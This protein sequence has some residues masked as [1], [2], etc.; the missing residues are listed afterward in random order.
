MY[1][2]C[3]TESQIMT[4]K[5]LKRRNTIIYEYWK[6]C[7]FLYET[8]LRTHM[9]NLKFYYVSPSLGSL[10][11]T[12]GSLLCGCVTAWDLTERLVASGWLI[13]AVPSNFY[14]SH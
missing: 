1:Q 11:G 10:A 8:A 7:L 3:H 4:S 6:N 9:L 5:V 14:Q 13:K 12:P 2:S